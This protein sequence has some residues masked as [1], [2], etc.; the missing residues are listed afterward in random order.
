MR[1]SIQQQLEGLGTINEPANIPHMVIEPA[2]RQNHTEDF[3]GF[4]AGGEKPL[5]KKFEGRV[6]SYR[7]GQQPQYHNKHP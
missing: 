3:Q 2:S 7:F 4:P 5:L 6:A 1:E